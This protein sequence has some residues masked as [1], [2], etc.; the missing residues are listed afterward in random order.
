MTI[1]R[2]VIM[3]GFLAAAGL[4]GLGAGFAAFVAVSHRRAGPLPT[5]DG[6]V[7]LTG[8]ADRV[9]TAF[10]LLDAGRAK[11][12]LVSGVAPAAGLDDLARRA[13]IEPAHLAPRVT[14]GRAATTTRGNAD[15]AGEWARRHNFH[16]LIIVTA[17][18]HM[19]RAMLEMRRAMPDM[20]LYPMPVQPQAMLRTSKARLL[21]SEYVKFIATWF[22]LSQVIRHPV[23]WVRHNPVDK[24]VNG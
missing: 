21:L 18:Y 9:E 3:L 16:S 2:L 15:E 17:G 6:I 23:E 11:W 24:S 8:G 13:E 19:P 14:L 10:H 1:R 12:L 22:G 4:M 5:A 20:V 7:A